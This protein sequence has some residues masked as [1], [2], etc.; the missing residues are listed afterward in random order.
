MIA[1]LGIAIEISIFGLALSASWKR[2]LHIQST[3]YKTHKINYVDT[4]TKLGQ[5]RSLLK[6]AGINDTHSVIATT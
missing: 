1:K 6:S 5:E 3:I 4:E 2:A